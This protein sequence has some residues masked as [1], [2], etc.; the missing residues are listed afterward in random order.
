MAS[1][2]IS[3]YSDWDQGFTTKESRLDSRQDQEIFILY[4]ALSNRYQGIFPKHSGQALKLTINLQQMIT[5]MHAAA[6]PI[7]HTP[8]W[9]GAEQTTLNGF[10]Y[11]RENNVS[12]GD[13]VRCSWGLF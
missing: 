5:R 10:I 6:L 3:R 4:P 2:Q 8:S 7:F 9:R 12:N 11:F 1:T 13:C